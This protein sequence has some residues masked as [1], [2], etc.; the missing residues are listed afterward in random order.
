MVIGA[1]GSGKST[2]CNSIWNFARDGEIPYNNKLE[3]KRGKR[4]IF[5]RSNEQDSKTY[6]PFAVEIENEGYYLVD[7]PGLGENRGFILNLF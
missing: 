5:E 4:E 6:T 7:N 2:T 1:T 3:L